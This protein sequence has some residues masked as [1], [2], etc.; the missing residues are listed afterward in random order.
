MVSRFSNLVRFPQHVCVKPRMLSGA[1]AASLATGSKPT[2]VSFQ[3]SLGDGLPFTMPKKLSKIGNTPLVSVGMGIYAKLE[4]HTPGGSIKDRTLS[5]IIL[6]MFRDGRLKQKGDTLCLVTSGSA[7]LSLVHIH[8]ALQQVPGMQLNIVVVFP[9]AYAHKEI[10]AEVIGMNQTEVFD[11]SPDALT[12]KLSSPGLYT[13]SQSMANVLLLDGVFMDVLAE[14]KSLAAANGWQ[15][16]DQHY[17]ENSMQGHRSTAQELMAGLPGLTDVVCATGTGATAAGL[18]RHLPP[19]IKVHS[20]PAVSGTIDG[21]SDVQRYDNFCD[22]SKLEGYD[23]CVFD[24]ATAQADTATL[25]RDFHIRAGPSSGSTFWLARQVQEANEDAVV[26][27]LC[28]DGTLEPT[29]EWKRATQ[30]GL[31]PSRLSMPMPRVTPRPVAPGRRLNQTFSRGLT[32]T[33]TR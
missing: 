19:H 2:N 1:A 30:P 11:R 4:G 29:S 7:G 3:D 21:L 18:R 28:A 23:S 22:V 5:S 12:S 33:H 9:K 8:E 24:Q 31:P 14:A 13:H 25:L 6:S 32:T 10:P 20:R 17:D 15:M 16:L 27:F 26:A